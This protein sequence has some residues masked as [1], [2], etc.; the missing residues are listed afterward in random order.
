MDQPWSLLQVP[1]ATKA[2]GLLSYHPLPTCYT[3]PSSEATPTAP[4]SQ[5]YLTGSSI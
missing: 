3:L 2:K 1:R 4:T 5:I